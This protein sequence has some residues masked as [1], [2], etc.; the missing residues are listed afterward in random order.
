M[1]KKG[2]KK[3]PWSVPELLEEEFTIVEWDGR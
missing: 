3:E 1:R 2:T